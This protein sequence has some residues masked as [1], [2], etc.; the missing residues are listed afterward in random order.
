MAMQKILCPFCG[1]DKV[2]FN[3]KDQH[4]NQRCMCKNPKCSHTTFAMNYKN[5]GS[6]PG[7]EEEI[8]TLTMNGS[9]VRDIARVLDVSKDKV[10]STLRKLHEQVQYVNTRY[11]NSLDPSKQLE[12]DI[13][14]DDKFNFDELEEINDIKAEADE[15]WSFYQR[16]KQ[17]IWLWWLVDHNTNTPIAFVFGDKKHDNLLKLLELVKDYDIS[18]FYVDGNPVYPKC[19][20]SE[21]LT[22]SKKNTQ[23]IERAHL[24]LRTR[25]KRLARKTICFSKN[26]TM[27]IAVVG[28][29]INL[30]FFRE[31]L[32]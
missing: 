9:G 2:V 23:Q 31:I 30:Y 3:G 6:K 21:K 16:K 27:H 24:T 5:N 4:G 14:K 7:I 19:I 13:V 17:Q 11:L 12:C 25:L 15:M 26:M 28:T 1:S 29:F 18:M 32:L 10:I 22:V 20:P 8:I